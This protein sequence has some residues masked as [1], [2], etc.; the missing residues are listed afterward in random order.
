MIIGLR[1]NGFGQTL[2]RF[3]IVGIDVRFG[4]HHH[5]NEILPSMEVWNQYL[6][7][8]RWTSLLQRTDACNEKTRPFVIQIVPRHR[9]DHHVPEPKTLH[10]F[11]QSMRLLGIDRTW[12]A[13]D[14]G[15]E[16]A[17]PGTPIAQDEETHI[18]MTPT[19]SQIG[20]PG[21]LAHRMELQFFH[22]SLGIGKA[23]MPDQ[24]TSQPEGEMG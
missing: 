6:H 5:P 15:A 12:T 11:R 17:A 2:D 13:G 14:N 3:Y 22:Q 16:T 18:P 10:R 9:C 21:F 1:P 24:R 7:T 20:T 4:I 8:N 23:P 19:L